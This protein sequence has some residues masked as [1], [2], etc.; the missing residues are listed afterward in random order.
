MKVSSCTLR[1]EI[2][3]SVFSVF[4]HVFGHIAYSNCELQASVD[5]MSCP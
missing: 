3:K 5:L 2:G 1:P 4:G